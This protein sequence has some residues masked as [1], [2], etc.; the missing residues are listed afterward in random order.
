MVCERNGTL[1]HAFGP[2]DDERDFSDRYEPVSAA[3]EIP[4]TSKELDTLLYCTDLMHAD[5]PLWD[6]LKA[7]KVKL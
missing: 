4:F 5:R 1:R 3:V 6:K 2:T 7:H